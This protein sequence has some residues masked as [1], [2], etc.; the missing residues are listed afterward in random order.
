MTRVVVLGGSGMLGST[1]VASL[2]T[3]PSLEVHASYRAAALSPDERARL[4]RATW[5]ELDA[6]ARALDALPRADWIVNAIGLIKPLIR[7]AASIERAIAVNAAFPYR[8]ARL[9]RA[10]GAKVIQIATDCVYSGATGRYPERAPHDALDVYGKSK[11]LGEVHA[12][13]F[14][15]LRCSIIGRD[16]RTRRSLLEWFLGHPRSGTAPG[17]T[18]HRWNGV[19]T[20]AFARLVR[21]IV[22]EAWRDLPGEQHVVPAD[23]VTKFDL[24]RLFARAFGRED[25]TIT[26]TRTPESVDRTLTTE[27]PAANA[28]LWRAAGYGTP[29]TLEALVEELAAWPHPLGRLEGGA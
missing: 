17:F 20:L 26:P 10:S 3:D 23:E 14:I 16:P 7:D 29:P 24:L 5:F 6:E 18:N 1:L 9:A 8:L 21:G 19:T 27:H 22:R 11:S 25:V 4:G 2:S 12:P 15:N 28:L 13:D